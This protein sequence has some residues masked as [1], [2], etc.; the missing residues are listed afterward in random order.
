M[1]VTHDEHLSAD[2]LH[3]LL[4][5]Q[6]L[7]P[8]PDSPL[9]G[10]PKPAT[11][12][13]RDALAARGLLEGAWTGALAILQQPSRRFRT[14][15]PFASESAIT[16]Y[17][18]NGTGRGAL[19]GCWP[20]DGRLRVSFPYA[21]EDCLRDA[22][23]QLGADYVAVRDPFRAELTPAGLAMMAAAVDELRR[24]LFESL[25][26]RNARVPMGLTPEQLHRAYAEG[27]AGTDARW[28]VTL[29]GLLMPA[30]APLPE[31]LSD[32]GVAE[33]IGCGLIEAQGDGW[34]ATE[35]LR[36][37]AA[38]LKSP[39]PAI[40]HEVLALD[41]R[42]LQ[43]YGY[44]IGLRG[45]GPVWTLLFSRAENGQPAIAL[46]AHT[47]AGYRKLLAEILAPA[48]AP[49]R[50]TGSVAAAEAARPQAAERPRFCPQCGA[51]AQPDNTFCTQCGHRL[52]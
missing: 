17:Y 45:D 49:A 1:A 47:G 6:G 2:E 11:E 7:R 32:A 43:S 52:A 29:L 24:R 34:Q 27:R 14:V 16:L 37:L 9:M 50:E 48:Y 41:G 12:V 26:Q 42:G 25:L 36:R 21:L 30:S 23:A 18:G 3:A 33:L 4:Q 39:L 8:T 51:N 10:L 15:V 20:E 22:S 35:P 44:L 19:V 28:L 13:R 5:Q 46:R 31:H 38:Y 40:A